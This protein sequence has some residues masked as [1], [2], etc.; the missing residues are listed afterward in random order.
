MSNYFDET[1][2]LLEMSRNLRNKKKLNEKEEEILFLSDNERKSEEEK[3]KSAVGSQ[4]QFQD[5]KIYKSGNVEFRGKLMT[6][7]IDWTFSLDDTEGCYIFSQT[8]LQLRDETL[9]LLNKLKG[10]YMVWRK[11]WVNKVNEFVN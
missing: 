8:F 6:E 3:F 7:G 2:H 1:K 5:F 11:D 10:Y 9:D 4:V